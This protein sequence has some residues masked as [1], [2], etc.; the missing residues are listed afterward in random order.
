M[1]CINTATK[2]DAEQQF[3]VALTSQRLGPALPVTVVIF[4]NTVATQDAEQQLEAA[5]A[6]Q[7]AAE[8]DAESQREALAD[9]RR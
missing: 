9:A 2:Q 6:S 7:R 8:D 1:I 5:L 3:Q 4:I